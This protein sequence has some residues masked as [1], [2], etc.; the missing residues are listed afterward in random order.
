MKEKLSQLDRQLAEQLCAILAAQVKTSFEAAIAADKW[1]TQHNFLVNAGGA[2]A[3]LSFI[4]SGT[5]PAFTF[6]P[7]SLFLLGVIASGVEI[8]YL[9]KLHGELHQDAI[10]RRGGFVADK[11][12]VAETA[13]VQ[14][15]RKITRNIN[16]YCG[17]IAQVAFIVGSLIGLLGLILHEL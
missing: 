11:L 8:R 12:T 15:P 5:A 14:A 1:L 6:V 3:V 7:L 17:L 16:H 2:A 9:M 13:D 4:G 10:R